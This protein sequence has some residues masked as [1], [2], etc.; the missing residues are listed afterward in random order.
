MI[1]SRTGGRLARRGLV[2]AAVVVGL[3]AF[4]MGPALADGPSDEHYCG[5]RGFFMP[6]YDNGPVTDVV[7][8]NVEPLAPSLHR[9]NCDN[10]EALDGAVLLLTDPETQEQAMD[11][12]I[13][14]KES[15]LNQVLHL[16]FLPACHIP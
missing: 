16:C 4:G 1:G 2:A 8:H 14:N 6:W 3:T 13:H 5:I 11:I 10:L 15:Y 12:L 7:H 9:I